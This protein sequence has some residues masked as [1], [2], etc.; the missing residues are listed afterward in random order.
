MQ[1]VCPDCK[2]AVSPDQVNMATDLAFCPDC[3]S[4]FK[5][6]STLSSLASADVPRTPPPGGAWLRKTM[7]ETVVGATTR[8]WIAL[9]LVPFMVV[10][11]GLSLGGIYWPQI[12]KGE[13][14]LIP[15]LF[16]I[17]FV[18]GSLVFWSLAL[19][20]IWGKVEVTIGPRSSVF[21]GVGSVGWRRAIDWSSVH[22]IREERGTVVYPGGHG[23]V[24]VLD[25]SNR[26][27]FG[28]G[29]NENR[30]YYLL[31]VLKQLRG[32]D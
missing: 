6:S 7:R 2:R 11:S 18:L 14:D 31:N 29:L 9:L 20:A 13:F 22:T 21:V 25:G 16:G 10:W 23:H 24:I 5:I 12:L 26:V 3:E 17:P 30:R 32:G 28:S 27:V 19:M 4:A 15:S 8:S 1:V